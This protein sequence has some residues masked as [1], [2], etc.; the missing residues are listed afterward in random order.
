MPHFFDKD[1]K[2]GAH[3]IE[4]SFQPNVLFLNATSVLATITAAVPFSLTG[5]LPVTIN[6]FLNVF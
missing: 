4:D 3:L 2:R 1:T 5:N 6:T